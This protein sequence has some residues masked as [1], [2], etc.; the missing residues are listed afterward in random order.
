MKKVLK[1]IGC[2]LLVVVLLFGSFVAWLSI[3]EYKPEDVE[4]IDVSATQ[5]KKSF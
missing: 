3:E 1:I 5:G 2:I 4:K